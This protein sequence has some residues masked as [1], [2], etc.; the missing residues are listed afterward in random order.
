MSA[1]TKTPEALIVEPG[2]RRLAMQAMYPDR[3][4]WFEDQMDDGPIFIVVTRAATDE[5]LVSLGRRFSVEP[6]A[7]I[8]FR[9]SLA[10]GVAQ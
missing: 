10:S 2:D 3:A 9:D 1:A 8:D 6:A 7:L 5:R 4:A